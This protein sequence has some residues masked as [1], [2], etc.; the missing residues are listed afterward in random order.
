MF[1]LELSERRAGAR[2]GWEIR[3]QSWDFL[4]ALAVYLDN[5][6]G[7]FFENTLYRE[8]NPITAP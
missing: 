8:R 7:G 2:R 4:G 3:V 6:A 1:S 5:T